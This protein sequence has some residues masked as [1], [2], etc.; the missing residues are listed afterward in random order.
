MKERRQRQAAARK[1]KDPSQRAASKKSGVAK[2]N[3]GPD[4]RKKDTKTT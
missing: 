2:P 1:T 4:A 3:T